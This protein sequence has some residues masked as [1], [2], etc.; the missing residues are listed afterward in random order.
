MAKSIG[1]RTE[2]EDFLNR[3]PLE[4]HQITSFLRNLL[5]S[6]FPFLDEE[7]KFCTLVY[8]TNRKIG[9]INPIRDSVNLMIWRGKELEDKHNILK[10]SNYSMR[11]VEITKIEDVD[12][13]YII[14]LFQQTL[15]LK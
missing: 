8:W 12:V 9:S 14:E 3:I 5:L 6:N 10:G 2:F 7:G 1:K 11:Y 13:D 4:T 15:A